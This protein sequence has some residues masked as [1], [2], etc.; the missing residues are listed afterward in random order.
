MKYEIFYKIK[1]IKFIYKKWKMFD[2]FKKKN[3]FLD[4]CI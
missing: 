4:V 1:K 2:F 3:R